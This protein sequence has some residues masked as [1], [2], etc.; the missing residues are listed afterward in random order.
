MSV[1]EFSRDTLASVCS[2]RMMPVEQKRPPAL[3]ALTAS[4]KEEGRAA[5]HFCPGAI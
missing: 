4:L 3:A 1:E 2:E 5:L